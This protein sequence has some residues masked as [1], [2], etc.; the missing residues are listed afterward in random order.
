MQRFYVATSRQLRRLDAK[1]RSPIYSHF[2]ET[3][4]G[5]S[6]VRAFGAQLRFVEEAE[7]RIDE[8]THFRFYLYG[9]NR[10]VNRL[11]HFDF[12]Y[13]LVFLTAFLA[14]YIVYSCLSIHYVSK[15]F[16]SK[17]NKRKCGNTLS[18]IMNL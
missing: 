17:R 8:N 11:L 18:L 14:H 12:V 2:S 1:F 4:Q 16:S 13:K 6:V 10:S 5:C 7:R 9:G 15:C 3:L